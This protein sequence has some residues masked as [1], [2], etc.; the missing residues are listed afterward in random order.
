MKTAAENQ[1]L[2][3]TA[4]IWTN[5]DN[6]PIPEKEDRF[7]IVTND[8]F[9]FLDL[10][11][12]WF[13]EGDLQFGVFRKKG[14][15]LKYV[16]KEKTHTPGTIRAIPYKV[17]NR[18]ANLTSRNPSTHAEAVDNIYPANANALWKAGLAPPVF[19]TMGDLW[20][21]Q[22]EK[23]EIEKERDISEKTNKNVYFYVEYS[24]YFSRSNHRVIDRLKKSFN[25]TWL[26]VRM[27]SHIFNNLA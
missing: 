17:L 18:L 6:S 22:D 20:R 4:E 21:N 8:E 1:H 16:G 25:L 26:R 23:V 12:S 19:P 9:P 11:M 3:F 7:Q 13:P 2:Q 5:E 14:K 27:S 24:R 15:Q 10:K